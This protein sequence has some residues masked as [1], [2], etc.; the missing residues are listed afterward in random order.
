MT[1]TAKRKTPVKKKAV[2]AEPVQLPQSHAV[3]WIVV[4]V[5]GAVIFAPKTVDHA[6]RALGADVPPSHS[7]PAK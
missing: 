7:A 2:Q 5:L 3:F 6:A 1:K 4:I